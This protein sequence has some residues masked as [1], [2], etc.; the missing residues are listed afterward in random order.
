MSQYTPTTGTITKIDWQDTDPGQLGCALRFTL[1]S[2]DQ[3]LIHIIVDGSTYVADNHPSSVGDQV[4]FFYSLY[5]PV[6]MIYPPQY[7]AVAAVRTP[8]G[9][10]ASLD[11]FTQAADSRQL[12]NSDNTLRLNL[13]QCTKLILPNGQ[14]FGGALSGK[15]LLVIYGA[16]TRSIP[17]Q[18]TP[19][20]I[21][22]FCQSQ[23][24]APC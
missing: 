3:G 9:T 17:A 20:K 12:V 23:S 8:L 11:V 24:S 16:T 15:L 6:P 10:Y 2:M 14:P 7:Q 4:T 13:S 22:V 18:T 5:A 19:D 1:N 21:I